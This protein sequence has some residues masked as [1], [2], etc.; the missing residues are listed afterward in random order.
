M[1]TRASRPHR[2]GPEGP[3]SPEGPA[4]SPGSQQAEAAQGCGLP[5]A[6]LQ[7]ATEL[8][9]RP[10]RGTTSACS[11]STTWP[12]AEDQGPGVN[13]RPKMPP[14]YS[15]S[16]TCR[17]AGPPALD[18]QGEQAQAP[19]G[20]SQG[21]RGPGVSGMTSWLPLRGRTGSAT[22]QGGQ[23]QHQLRRGRR[24]RRRRGEQGAPRTHR[25]PGAVWQRQPSMPHTAWPPR[26]RPPLSRP[27]AVPREEPSPA[28]PGPAPAR[29]V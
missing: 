16:P 9:L 26:R 15:P 11:S 3:L 14:P 19:R 1:A 21:R 24:R 5:G 4:P 20:G 10:P 22:R 17:R 23:G 28:P 29:M 25:C 6:W 18:D 2:R 13:I 12:P 27:C 7:L 8:L